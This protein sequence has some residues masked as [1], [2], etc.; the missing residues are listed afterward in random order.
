MD[1]AHTRP[2]G[3]EEKEEVKMDLTKATKEELLE[4]CDKVGVHPVGTVAELKAR[5]EA[6]PR[7]QAMVNYRFKD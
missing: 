5:L 7:F 6:C 3:K 1:D 4:L 2:I